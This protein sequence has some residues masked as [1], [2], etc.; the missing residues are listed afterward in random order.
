MSYLAQY[1]NPQAA[2][3]DLGGNKKYADAPVAGGSAP[4]AN[5]GTTGVGAGN[6]G[7]SITGS[8]QSPGLMGGGQYNVQQQVIDPNAFTNPVGAN[9][10]T[11]YNQGQNALYNASNAAAPTLAPAALSS[12]AGDQGQ[13]AVANQEMGIGT[14]AIQG[15]AAKTAALQ[16]AQNQ[17]ANLSA[18]GSARG[19]ANPALAGY[20]VGQANAN[21][22]NTAAQNAVTGAANEQLGALNNAQA[23][24]AG[25]TQNQ[26]ANQAAI[27]QQAQAQAQLQ[28]QQMGLQGQ[29]LANYV[30]ANAGQIANTMQAQQSQQQ[31][32]VQNTLG[33][34]GLQSTAY[35]NAAGHSLGAALTGIAGAGL[36]AA[37]HALIPSDKN[38]KKNIKPSSDV[39]KKFLTKMKVR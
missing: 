22:Q 39:L 2:D 12:G 24:Y 26:Q 29:E 28:A 14:G 37:A 35:N 11:G 16:S 32:Q 21:V 15:A 27:N 38:L 3:L 36:G 8:G 5:G 13:L 20:N 10:V 25:V 18:M 4:I 17:Q 31:L 6:G 19:T 1:L 9:S 30:S 7:N 34:Q 23:G 33:T